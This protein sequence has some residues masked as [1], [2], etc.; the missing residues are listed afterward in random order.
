MAR[1]AEDIGREKGLVILNPDDDCSPEAVRAWFDRVQSG[2]PVDPGISAAEILRE[3]RDHG[4][5]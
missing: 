5:E 4:E 2:D 1:R 3:I